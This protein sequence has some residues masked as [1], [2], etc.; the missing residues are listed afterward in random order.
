M[1]FD[2][3][4]NYLAGRGFR[5]K[6]VRITDVEDKGNKKEKIRAGFEVTNVR[7]EFF[8]YRL[9][10]DFDL[11]KRLPSGSSFVGRFLTAGEAFFRSR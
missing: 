5:L 7:G 3:E 2:E 11:S 1:T 4:I 6:R 9:T 8:L 10:Y